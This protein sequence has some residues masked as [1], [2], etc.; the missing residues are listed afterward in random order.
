MDCDN[1]HF[2]GV[3]FLQYKLNISLTPAVMS[4]NLNVSTLVLRK[5]L[6]E[7][8]PDTSSLLSSHEAERSHSRTR[9]C[10]ESEEPKK[11]VLNCDA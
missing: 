11:E 1:R 4:S 7:L 2:G 6:E 8:T 10:R 3:H 9:V 5:C